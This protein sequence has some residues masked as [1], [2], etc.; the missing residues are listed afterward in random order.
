[1]AS[2]WLSTLS[3][4]RDEW[5]SRRAPPLVI[6]GWGGPEQQLVAEAVERFLKLRGYPAVELRELPSRAAAV[7]AWPTV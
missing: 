2:E 7:E 4:P 1:M 6:G 3:L 5:R